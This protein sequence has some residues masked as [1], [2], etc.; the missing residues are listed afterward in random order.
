[1]RI[2]SHSFDARVLKYRRVPEGMLR[3]LEGIGVD[4]PLVVGVDLRIDSDVS[5]LGGPMGGRVVGRSG[6]PRAG[7]TV[8]HVLYSDR[9]IASEVGLLSSLIM[10]PLK[11]IKAIGIFAAD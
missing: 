4:G 6:W 3:L 5:N 10:N 1:M 2:G 8:L 11:M 9:W 7:R